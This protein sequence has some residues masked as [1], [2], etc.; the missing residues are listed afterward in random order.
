VPNNSKVK[1]L[2]DRIGKIKEG[3]ELIKRY[4]LVT[5]N[6]ENVHKSNSKKHRKKVILT[7]ISIK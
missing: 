6:N 1:K 7:D 2:I 5:T 3:I 4:M